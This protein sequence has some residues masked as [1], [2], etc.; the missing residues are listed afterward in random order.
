[1]LRIKRQQ[2]ASPCAGSHAQCV[3]LPNPEKGLGVPTHDPT[4]KATFTP[5]G[6]STLR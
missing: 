6:T 5:S 1:M 4:T 2:A 3:R